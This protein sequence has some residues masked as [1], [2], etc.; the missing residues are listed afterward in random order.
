[1]IVSPGLGTCPPCPIAIDTLDY[2]VCDVF[3]ADP[4]RD[5]AILTF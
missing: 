4:S 1:V 3:A 5:L 2:I